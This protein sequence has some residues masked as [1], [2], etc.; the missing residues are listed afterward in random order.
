M[1]FSL[2]LSAVSVTAVTAFAPT[3]F[4]SSN[5]KM[6]ASSASTELFM[7]LKSGESKAYMIEFT[8]I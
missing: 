2:F 5:R 3:A 7:A 6:R 1:K 4:V 8:T